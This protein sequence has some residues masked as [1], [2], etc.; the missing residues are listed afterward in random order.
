VHSVQLPVRRAIL[1]SILLL[2]AAACTSRASAGDPP[3][4]LPSVATSSTSSTMPITLDAT[5]QC[6][7]TDPGRLP[8]SVHRAIHCPDGTAVTVSG[9]LV[10]GPG[11]TQLLCDSA[12]VS[13]WCLT[14]DGI[15]PADFPPAVSGEVVLIGTVSGGHLV[16][17]SHP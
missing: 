16:A 2:G 13:D 3:V 7:W 10:D 17:R 15:T 11:A 1:T 8:I 9:V 6:V 14:V 5:V 4:V 12:L